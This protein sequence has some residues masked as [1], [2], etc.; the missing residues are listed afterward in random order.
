MDLDV[1]FL[2]TAGAVPTAQRGP[3][4]YLVRRGG[5]R[6]LI[7]CGEGTQR[8]M[9]RSSAGLADI[10]LA[11]ITHFHADH[12]LGLP[13]MLK[14]FALRA[15]AAPLT[16]H[17]PS[18]LRALIGS[19]D[20]V[21]GRLSYPLSLVELEPGQTLQ[22]DGYRIEPFATDHGVASLGYALCEDIRPGRFDMETATALG[23]PFGP[24]CGELQRGRPVALESGA[25]V[26][27]EQVVGAPRPGRRIVFSGDTRPCAGTREASA[28]ADLLVHEA[29]FLEEES[30]RA[31]E[32][33]H[34][35]AIQAAQLALDAQV[36][37]L[38]LT[39]LSTRYTG[40]QMRREARAVGWKQAAAEHLPFK[41][42]WFDAAHAHLVMHVVD[43]AGAALSEMARVLCPGGR[44]VVVSFRREHFDRFH[45]NPYFPTLADIDRARFPDPAAL[46]AA[47]GGAG[48]ED[49]AERGLHQ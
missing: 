22:R 24:L 47:I 39:H 40:G 29:T 43:D 35:T 16:I 12:V 15:R 19:L 9:L 28:A 26:T 18:G 6:I 37:M 27:P 14:T 1:V 5:E 25:V 21:I 2:G 48:F 23:V 36:T 30:E 34:S 33:A 49:V 8:Q 41:D 46:S 7:D 4:A 17:G 11:L 38:A 20:R 32:T 45:L 31:G 10:D 13:G 44:L 42:G 3:A